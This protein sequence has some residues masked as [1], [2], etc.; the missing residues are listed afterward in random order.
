MGGRL[1]L[2]RTFCGRKITVVHG[3]ITDERV[4]AVVN[5]ANSSLAHGGGIAGAIVRKGGYIIQEESNKIGY[6]PVGKAA[7]TTAGALPS[8]F[9]IHVV[10]PVWG[11]GDEERKLRSAVASAL[12]LA[13]DMGLAS[14]SIPA[15]STGIFGYPKS[16][17][18]DVIVDEVFRW[19]SANKDSSL[20]EIRFVALDEETV[21]LFE[22][23]VTDRKI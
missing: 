9:V 11:E 7:A 6:L 14:I 10:G 20:K 2:S 22:K 4:D 12:N 19:L 16:R 3:D 13:S 5:P 17:G 8:R 1:L 23:A 15:I 21:K 18:V